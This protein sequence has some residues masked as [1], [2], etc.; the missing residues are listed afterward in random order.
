MK[1][2]TK[3]WVIIIGLIALIGIGGAF[4]Y[5]QVNA[6]TKQK[7]VTHEVFIKEGQLVHAKNVD[8][9]VNKARVLKN[10]DQVTVPVTISIQQKGSANYGQKKN[11]FNY[12]ENVWLNIPYGISNQT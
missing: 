5:H 3:I 2:K 4:R 9:T 10:K 1:S 12:L 6:N 7:G 11:N 8:F